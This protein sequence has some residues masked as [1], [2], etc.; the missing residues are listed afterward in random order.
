MTTVK[1]ARPID[2]P[3]AAACS[4]LMGLALLALLC[5]ARPDLPDLAGADAGASVRLEQ[6]G[7]VAALLRFAGKPQAVEVRSNRPLPAKPAS[8]EPA[9]V[10]PAVLLA[11][12]HLTPSPAEAAGGESAPASRAGA[13]RPRAPPLA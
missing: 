10:P 8:G 2:R 4:L 9:I 1:H 13:H 5:L 11:G 7:E 3:I 12:L 6:R